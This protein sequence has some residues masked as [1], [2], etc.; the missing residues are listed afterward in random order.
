MG[1]TLVVAGVAASV[2]AAGV[3]ATPTV[4]GPDA[5]ALV[6]IFTQVIDCA[7]MLPRPKAAPP[8][9]AICIKP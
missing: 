5:D 8:N 9:L 2:V 3:A 7:G 6:I 4:E 1:V